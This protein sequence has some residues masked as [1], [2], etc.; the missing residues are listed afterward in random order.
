M[1]S[2][3][4]NSASQSDGIIRHEVTVPE[5]RGFVEFIG[6]TPDITARCSALFM[7]EVYCR[8][9]VPTLPG[10]PAKIVAEVR[11][12]EG[13]GSSGTRAA[14]EFD[15]PPLRGFWKKHYLVG[16]M[17]SLAKN[18][19]LGLGKKRREL[20]RIIQEHWNPATAHLPPEAISRNIA[21]AITNLY[22]DRSLAQELTGEW[23]VF[24]R[25]EGQNYYLCLAMHEEVRADPNVLV[26]RIKNGC[27]PEFP[28][29]QEQLEHAARHQQ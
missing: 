21:N 2:A 25:H 17:G 14:E 9:R 8:A 24:A 28:F 12:L 4:P 11:G 10:D 19:M 13:L 27:V 29:L 22:A 23:I 1:T 5:V 26:E 3:S 7:F 18:I 6:L 20:R 16:G 15:R